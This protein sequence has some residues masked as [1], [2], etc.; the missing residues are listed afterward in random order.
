LVKLIV[1]KSGEVTDVRTTGKFAGTPTGACLE[2]AVGTAKFPP[3]D[4][5]SV[6]YPFHLKGNEPAPD[7]DDEI[8][9]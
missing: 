5:V 9:Q 4:G 2:R 6:M 7:P 8:T 1:G 3:S